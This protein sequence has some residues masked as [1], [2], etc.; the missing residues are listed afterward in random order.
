MIEKD[1]GLLTHVSWLVAAPLSFTLPACS[2][3]VAVLHTHT[4]TLTIQVQSRGCDILSLKKSKKKKSIQDSFS[5]IS[6]LFFT[7]QI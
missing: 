2:L 7:F 3:T 6:Q 1:G 4:H 5:S